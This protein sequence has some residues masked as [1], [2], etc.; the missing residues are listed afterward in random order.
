MPRLKGLF[1]T[2][3]FLWFFLVATSASAG[4]ALSQC[5]PD[6]TQSSGAIYR[7]CMPAPQRWNG[8]LVLFAHGYVAFNEPVAI[9]E[10]QL[11]PPGGICL[12]TLVNSLGFAFATTSYSTNGLAVLPGVQDV[13]DL[14]SVF[15]SAH[16]APGHVYLTGASE[17]GIVTAL[18][19]EQY[20]AVFDGGLA[21]C[22]PIGDWNRQIDY[23]GDFRVLFD[24]FFPGLIPG[25]PTEIPEEVIN[26]FDDLYTN[27]IRPVVFA[28]ANR[29]LLDQLLKTAKVP[30]DKNDPT[31]IETSIHDAL[32]YDV[33]ATNDA[34]LK[35]GGQPFDNMKRIYF[36]SDNDLRLNIRV[37][38]VSADA[39]ATAEIAA[40]YQ[41]TGALSRPLVTLHTTKDQQVP[42]VHEILY[43]R[44]VRATGST[45]LHKN[46]P[47]F[48]YGHCNFKPIDVVRAFARLVN[49]ATGQSI[50]LQSVDARPGT[51]TA[52]TASS[53]RRQGLLPSKP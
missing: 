33:F 27:M 11:C 39:A 5:E 42:Y 26:N 50:S 43:Q 9:P 30:Y 40:H 49:L 10:D 18:A 12:P 45:P 15:T 28:P 2:S 22:G 53:V 36:G 47:V 6:A 46:I 32:W 23:F 34:T 51:P 19:I 21:A 25:S 7:I 1:L 31:T 38:R 48:R 16:G 41:T 24:Y 17:G 35:L 3:L 4:T 8:D 13:V 29:H 14:V 37:E 20:P 52:A 44:K